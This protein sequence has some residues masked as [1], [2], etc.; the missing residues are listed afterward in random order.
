[1]H[2]LPPQVLSEGR[3]P[4]NNLELKTWVGRFR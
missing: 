2:T 4:Y 1:M 3:A